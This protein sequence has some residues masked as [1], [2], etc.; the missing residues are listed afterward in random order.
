MHLV[1]A[2]L[3]YISSLYTRPPSS[4]QSLEARALDLPVTFTSAC[5]RQYGFEK[6]RLREME[7]R[8]MKEAVCELLINGFLRQCE[9]FCDA[10]TDLRGR[11]C[12]EADA[13]GVQGGC[14]LRG[15]DPEGIVPETLLPV[16]HIQSR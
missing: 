6:L 11:R 4:K 7:G 14:S 15:I 10:M 8:E 2:T 13:V 9:E 12:G 1:Q 3:D 16:S 5:G